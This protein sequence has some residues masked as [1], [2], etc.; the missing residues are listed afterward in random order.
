MDGEWSWKVV[1]D[2]LFTGVYG[3]VDAECKRSRAGGVQGEEDAKSGK[4][5][6]DR[7][8]G[9]SGSHFGICWTRNPHQKC[10]DKLQNF[11]VCSLPRKGAPFVRNRRSKVCCKILS[12]RGPRTCS[13]LTTLCTES[14]GCFCRREV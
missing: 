14:P 5:E 4:G 3:D 8:D 10:F 6:V 11:S 12:T 7:T 13:L 1:N 9:K 2:C